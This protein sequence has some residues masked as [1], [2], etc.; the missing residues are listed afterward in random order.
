M[1]STLVKLLSIPLI[2]L[3]LS[4]CGGGGSSPTITPELLSDYNGNWQSVCTYDGSTDLSFVETLYITDT[5]YTIY[6]DEF[7]NNNCFGTSEYSTEIEGYLYFGDY[8][9]YAS[10]YCSNTI[11]VDFAAVAVFE[12]GIKLSPSEISSFLDLPENTSY[13]LMCTV[14]DE[15]YTGDLSLDDGRTESTRPLSM[16]YDNPLYAFD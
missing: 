10:N 16:N 11:E 1:Q 3:V 15:L 8:K 5:D 2:S 12:D 14:N 13:N 7:D 9:P 4:A 6:I